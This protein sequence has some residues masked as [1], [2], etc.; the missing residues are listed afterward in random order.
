MVSATGVISQHLSGGARRRGG[1]GIIHGGSGLAPP[2]PKIVA[3]QAVGRHLNSNRPLAGRRSGPAPRR[4]LA[5]QE[6]VPFCCHPSPLTAT[7]R[8]IESLGF[9]FDFFAR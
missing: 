5:V 8:D 4:R 3:G 2:F 1:R 6:R 9:P 7:T